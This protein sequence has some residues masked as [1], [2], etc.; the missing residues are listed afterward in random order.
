MKARLPCEIRTHLLLSNCV[1]ANT[2]I[3]AS[4]AQIHCPTRIHMPT[5]ARQQCCIHSPK[6]R[7]LHC[8]CAKH[9]HRS[10]PHPH[11]SLTADTH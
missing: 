6:K 5:N 2:L 4:S 1:A 3:N 11:A 7:M 10:R 8:M 9:I